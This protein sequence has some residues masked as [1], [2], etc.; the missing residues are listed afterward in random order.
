MGDLRE[1]CGDVSKRQIYDDIA[2]MKE[3]Y[4][5][6]IVSVK[7]GGQTF[8]EYS[9]KSFTID[10]RPITERELQQIKELLLMLSQFN[11]IPQFDLVK[12]LITNINNEYSEYKEEFANPTQCVIS[13]D[14]NEYVFGTEHIPNIYEAIV[15]KI[16]LRINYQTFHKG[17]R[18]W[19]IHPYFLKQ[20]NNRW[21]LIGMSDDEHNNIVHVGLDRIIDLV[22][23]NIPFKE[24]DTIHNIDDYFEN[25]VGV[26]IPPERKIEHVVLKFSPHRFPY[27]K[28][29]PIHWSQ[30]YVNSEEGIIS[31][32][33]I[34]NRELESIIL[35]FGKD[36]EV[37]EP[38]GFR[39][40]IAATIKETYAKYFPVQ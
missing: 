24:N 25:I 23:V 35:N 33:L 30:K 18:T 15:N 38:L 34:R 13:L 12:T 27:V 16:P 37:I 36:V 40:E 3:H 28:A 8:Y 29:K 14:K 26:T 31:L 1:K 9:D 6:P 32:D 2:Y 5:A 39:N 21:Y 17:D 10:K 4:N 11:D 20:Y 19:I 22:S 7:A